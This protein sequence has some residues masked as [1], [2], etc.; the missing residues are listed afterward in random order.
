VGLLKQPLWAA[1]LWPLVPNAV[2]GFWRVPEAEK[3]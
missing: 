1:L 3:R 2:V